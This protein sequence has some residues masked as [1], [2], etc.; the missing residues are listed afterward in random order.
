MFSNQLISNVFENLSFFKYYIR[1]SF[2]VKHYSKKYRL[3]SIKLK[4]NMGYNFFK[5]YPKYSL[6]KVMSCDT[7]TMWKKIFQ[8]LKCSMMY[9]VHSKKRYDAKKFHL[10]HIL[11]TYWWEMIPKLS[12]L[13]P[14]YLVKIKITLFIYLICSYKIVC[15]SQQ[16]YYQIVLLNLNKK[17][18][19]LNIMKMIVDACF[20]EL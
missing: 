9:S 20:F 3:W 12:Y 10:L 18:H 17:K 8:S 1:L 19:I 2:S 7:N 13:L 5:C 15:E 14:T 4:S 6:C 16:K 11:I